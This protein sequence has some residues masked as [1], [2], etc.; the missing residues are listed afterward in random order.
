M[1]ES[2]H[3]QHDNAPSEQVID[4]G[5]LINRYK[6]YW[7]LFVASL[8]LCMG[9]AWAYLKTAKR[10]YA[11]TARV[12]VAQEDNSSS[13]GASLL[14]SLKL[15]GTG[16][17]VED[18]MIV[19][20]SQELCTQVAKQLGL[21]RSYVEDRGWFKP[22]VDHYKTSPIE[23]TAPEELFDTLYTGLKFKIDVDKQG[24]ANIKMSNS[25]KTLANLKGVTLP[26]TVKSPYGVFGIVATDHFKPGK[27][28]HIKASLIGNHYKG[29]GLNARIKVSLITKKANG[30]NLAINETRTARGKD[31]LNTLIDLL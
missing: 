10:V 16:G 21:N 30:I 26:A 28:C 29:E 11:V 3:T 31:V 8:V 20:S 1:V 25:K 7:W 5:A 4:F 23:V 27:E 14:K 18:E 12:L 22:Q 24:L 13:A 15:G 6:R 19:M 9:L 17:K 2:T